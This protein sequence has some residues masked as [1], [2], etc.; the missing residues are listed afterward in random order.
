MM[1]KMIEVKTINPYFSDMWN[2]DKPFEIRFN[3]RGYQKGDV[4][5]SRE[6]DP[7]NKTYSGREILSRIRY[8]I[9][10]G[11]FVGLAHG[12]CAMTVT[13]LQQRTVDL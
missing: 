7:E 9:P 4:L 13:V 10:E 12:Y 11:Q 3:D 6:Y 1:T 8:V 5:F 2:G